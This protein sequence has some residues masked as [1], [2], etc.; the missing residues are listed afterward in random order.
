MMDAAG[1]WLSNFDG[2]VERGER[3]P[4]VNRA[5]DRVA[6]G[7][8]RPGV[9]DHCDIGETFGNRDTD[10]RNYENAATTGFLSPG[11]L[12][13]HLHARVRLSATAGVDLALMRSGGRIRADTPLT[14]T[15]AQVVDDGATTGYAAAHAIPCSLFVPGRGRLYTIPKTGELQRFI[16]TPYSVTNIMPVAANNADTRAEGFRRDL[17]KGPGMVRSFYEY[18]C[19]VMA[20]GADAISPRNSFRP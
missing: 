11:Q 6:H 4:D 14:F 16:A 12:K 1:R 19:K 7:A 3:Q 20:V 18:A 15:G 8:A 9:Q 13:N 10:Y 17:G 2:G 5:A